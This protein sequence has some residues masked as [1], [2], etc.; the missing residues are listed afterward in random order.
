MQEA[1]RLQAARMRAYEAYNANCPQRATSELVVRSDDKADDT[2]EMS[3]VIYLDTDEAHLIESVVQSVDAFVDAL[4]YD[5][6]KS[7]A[8]RGSFFRQSW[9]KLR[10]GLTSDDVKEFS[11]QVQRS[12]ELRLLDGSQS[13]IDIKQAEAF[14]MVVESLADVPSACVRTGSILMVKY[15]GPGGPVVMSRNLSQ[16]EIKTLEKHPEIQR[17]PQQAFDALALAISS[18]DDISQQT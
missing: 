8:E 3:I 17:T 14:S 7:V 12:I 10:Q 13:E 5:I 15:P 9:A 11:A 2:R 1:E 18:L 16:L 4:G 6:Y